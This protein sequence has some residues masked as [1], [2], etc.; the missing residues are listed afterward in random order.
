MT[1]GGGQS[2]SHYTKDAGGF[3]R[4]RDNSNLTIRFYGVLSQTFKVTL[5]CRLYAH[6][7]LF[8]QTS[9]SFRD[10]KSIVSLYWLM[11]FYTVISAIAHF[12]RIS[13][14]KNC[15]VVSKMRD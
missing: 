7:R 9:I 10:T 5:E 12:L 15:T 1:G 6:H 13:L 14:K 2:F 3:Q 8:S 4:K 11:N